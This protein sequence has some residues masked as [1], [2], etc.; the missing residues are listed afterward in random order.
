MASGTGSDEGAAEPEAK[1]RAAPSGPPPQRGRRQTANI[2]ILMAL[3]S[4]APSPPSMSF[5]II[6]FIGLDVPVAKT[7]QHN[8]VQ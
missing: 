2:C 1:R 8:H 6:K 4:G 7:I 5:E 3:V